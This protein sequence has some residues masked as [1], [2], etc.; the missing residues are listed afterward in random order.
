MKW[1]DIL[2]ETITQGRVKEIED[3]DI[4]IE[5]DDCRRWLKQFID[6]IKS[7]SPTVSFED[8]TLETTSKLPEDFT[9]EEA[10]AIK[11]FFCE[12]VKEIRKEP[13]G[14]S[15]DIGEDIEVLVSSYRTFSL[16]IYTNFGYT[17][18]FANKS[19]RPTQNA[20]L[21]EYFLPD[22][23][24]TMWLSDKS[25]LEEYWE[26]KG[27]DERLDSLAMLSYKFG[28]EYLTPILNVVKRIVRHCNNKAY[29][30]LFLNGAAFAFAKLIKPFRIGEID[31]DSSYRYWR[32]S[33]ERRF[34]L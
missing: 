28:E 30:V 34:N 15:I 22:L 10:C 1:Q 14:M 31:L 19:N 20:N 21:I 5:E 8:E 12:E 11:D 7:Y 18:D 6:I 33:F 17:L 2:K 4:D 27:E 32:D 29:Y 9:E 13:Y 25:Q 16:G 26:E 24:R 3:I 23:D